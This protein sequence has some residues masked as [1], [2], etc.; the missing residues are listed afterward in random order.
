MERTSLLEW[1]RP[2]VQA[3]EEHVGACEACK[4]GS[5][6]PDKVKLWSLMEG[7]TATWLARATRGS[8]GR[9]CVAHELC[10]GTD[11]EHG[12]RQWPRASSV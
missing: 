6:C 11:P 3:L 9:R 10:W 1:L 7:A 4:E 2:A 8:G 5:S 12:H